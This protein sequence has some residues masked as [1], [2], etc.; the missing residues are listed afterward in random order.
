MSAVANLVIQ[1]KKMV[2]DMDGT[3]IRSRESKLIRRASGI[4]DTCLGRCTEV[5]VPGQGVGGGS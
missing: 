2:E 3:Q 1:F 4:Q 5:A